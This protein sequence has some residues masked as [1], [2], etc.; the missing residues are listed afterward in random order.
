MAKDAQEFKPLCNEI[1]L[2]ELKPYYAYHRVA[3]AVG[4]LPPR[5]FIVLQ[6]E[7]QTETTLDG[8]PIQ[9]SFRPLDYKKPDKIYL[10]V[11]VEVFNQKIAENNGSNIFWCKKG[12]TPEDKNT[13]LSDRKYA[14]HSK[15][16]F[17]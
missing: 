16:Y 11:T 17:G 9:A 5:P 10:E 7:P 13:I 3:Q 6:T 4:N 12:D 15:H 1:L 2:G 8:M 14:E